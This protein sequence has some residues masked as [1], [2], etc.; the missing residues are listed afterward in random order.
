[1]QNESSIVKDET[2]ADTEFVTIRIAGQ[3]FGIPVMIV[4]DVLCGLK[5]TRVPLAPSEVA[6]ALNLR[7]RIVTAIELRQCFDLPVPVDRPL[8]KVMSVVVE[9]KN[10]FFSLIVDSVGEVI[11][12]AASQIEKTPAILSGRWREASAG[13]YKL[14]DELLIILDVK[15]LL[16]F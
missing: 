12:L 10:E 14:K 5:I 8:D 4:Q 11:P 2:S 16:K 3:L 1:M 9:Y 15:K 6:G 13:I 7:G